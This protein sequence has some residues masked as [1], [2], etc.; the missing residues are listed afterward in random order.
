MNSRYFF[1]GFLIGTFCSIVLP[2]SLA[3]Q[4]QNDKTMI[5]H[6]N[7][8]FEKREY[9]QAFS[10]Y[11]KLKDVHTDVIAYQFRAGVCAIYYGDA[12]D[13]LSLIKGSYE[14][15]PTIPDI[16]FFLGR[17]YLLN[18]QYD[19]ASLQFNLQ[20]AKETD[21]TQKP[22][23]N[24]YIVNCQSAKDLSSKPTNNTVTNAGRPLNSPGDEFAPILT[25][26]DSV[27][28]FTY[29]GEE[30]TGGKNYTF[31]KSDSAGYYTEDIFESTLGRNGWF[32]P[33]S[34]SHNLNSKAN[35]AG[36]ALSPD[37][38]ILFIYRSSD[39]DG[40]DIYMARKAG[41]DWTTPV[42]LQGDVNKPD[43][44]EGS[45]TITKDGRTIYFAS[46]RAGGFGGKDIYSATLI[47]DSTWGNVQNLGS[48]I[49][50]PL[51]DDAPYL[52]NN[53]N[54]LYFSSRGSNSMGGY[55]IFQ[56][57][58]GTDGK[59]WEL[60]LNM[61][62][63]VNSTADD[64][65]YQP[66]KNGSSAVFSSNRSGGNGMMD[67]YFATPGIAATD[68]VTLK[69]TVTLDDM[70]IGA[71]VTVTYT[72][73]TDI[74]GDYNGSA[75]DG[76][77][78]I[79][80]PKGENYKLIFQVSGQD[81]YSKTYDATEVKTYTT[82]EINVEFFSDEYKMKH[83]ERFG[84]MTKSDS[85]NVPVRTMLDV[86]NNIYYIGDS[87][88]YYRIG[89]SQD[90]AEPGYYI[91]VGA[92][93]NIEFAKRLENKIKIK[94]Q[95]PKVERIFNTR[96]TLM[97]VTFGHPMTVDEAIKACMEARKEYPDAWV[98]YLK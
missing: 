61:G 56:S 28:I 70:P 87:A 33:A 93:K 49:N 84:A 34:L 81:E 75:E 31:G 48:N 24:Q 30:S 67:L 22:R 63:P 40:G 44:W 54:T 60:A 83:P 26:N 79:N 98:T 2:I 19:D 11:M 90:Q 36:T 50:T 41:K 78:T 92:F 14:K 37:G 57:Q 52:G 77:Y 76:K 39:K 62:V 53:E 94:P 43:S 51:D 95:Y 64:I 85:A 10:Y 13:A 96:K 32:A 66:S 9:E 12:E 23:L 5:D 68:L 25:Q 65:F 89:D 3:A 6:A 80:L 55:D 88:K 29:K 20:L 97:F 45:I 71:V 21:E 82:N 1:L 58:L 38:K 86:K 73:K 47:G 7:Q 8:L 72:N 18:G 17:A 91:T 46:D 35:D 16:N 4:A 69:G 27:L 74:Q 15:D 59:S 42:K